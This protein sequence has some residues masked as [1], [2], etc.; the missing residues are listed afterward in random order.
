V[1]Y[2]V[3]TDI[4]TVRIALDTNHQQY[5]VIEV[6]NTGEGITVDKIPHLFKRFQ[7]LSQHEASHEGTGLGLYFTKIVVDK[8]AGNISVDCI[9]QGQHTLTTF[10]ISLPYSDVMLAQ[11][12]VL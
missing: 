6:S 12:E 1:K 9:P 4:V 2:S 7:R 10:K 11:P 5:V 3:E 8:H